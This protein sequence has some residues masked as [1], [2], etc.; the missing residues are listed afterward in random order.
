M[1]A[2]KRPWSY[3]IIFELQQTIENLSFPDYNVYIYN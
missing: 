2:V 3:V 1:A